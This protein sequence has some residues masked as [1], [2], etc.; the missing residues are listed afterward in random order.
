MQLALNES[1]DVSNFNMK[2]NMDP[3]TELKHYP[4]I[5][6]TQQQ[7]NDSNYININIFFEN[8]NAIDKIVDIPLTYTLAQGYSNF[9]EMTRL[10][11]S[12]YFAIKHIIL[13]PFNNETCIIMNVL[14]AG[15]YKQLS[16]LC[17]N[18]NK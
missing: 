5:K 11:S 9:T 13:Q 16:L 3:W 10:W 4:A 6:V 18:N 1:K 12:P 2:K 15:K 7:I 8:I 14:Q 17:L